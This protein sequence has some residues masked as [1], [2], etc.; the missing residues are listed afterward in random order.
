MDGVGELHRADPSLWGGGIEESTSGIESKLHTVSHSFPQHVLTSML[1][2]P[3]KN[4]TIVPPQTAPHFRTNLCK[5]SYRH[6]HLG[7]AKISLR[8]GVEIQRARLIGLPATHHPFCPA[9]IHLT[10]AFLPWAK[11]RMNIYPK[12]LLPLL[13]A[14]LKGSDLQCV[15]D[16]ISDKELPW[17]HFLPFLCA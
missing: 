11:R 16:L 6:L 7:H 4:S 1:K 12:C 10:L 2:A 3:H 5:R 15:V 17:D 13:C 9:R 8:C 14:A